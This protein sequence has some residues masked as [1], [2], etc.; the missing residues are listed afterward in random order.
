MKIKVSLSEESILSAIEQL[1]ILDGEIQECVKQTVDI[2]ANEGSEIAQ[3]AY[4]NWN[5]VVIPD[6]ISKTRAE[7]T[8]GGDY[9]AMAEFGA[10][11][12]TLTGGFENFPNNVYPGSYS[13]EHAEQFSTWGFWEFAGRYYREIPAH[14]GLLNAKQYIIEN[15]TQIAQEVFNR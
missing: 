12:A 7:I 3:V 15:S 10:G 2:L 6:V 5:V 4:G 13:E 14:H 9:P 1:R 8:V 11:R